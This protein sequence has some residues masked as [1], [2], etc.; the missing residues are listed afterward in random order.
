MIEL[1][2]SALHGAGLED[3]P[4]SIAKCSGTSSNGHFAGC[5]YIT[6]AK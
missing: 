4:K 1:L 5:P 2:Q 6:T 3:H